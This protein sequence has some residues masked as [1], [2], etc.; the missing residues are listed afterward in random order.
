[1]LKVL[2]PWACI[3]FA[4]GVLLLPLRW[5]LA[6]GII[7]AAHEVGHILTAWL[8]G[9]RVSGFSAATWGARIH[10]EDLTP[11][12]ELL[13]ALS[14]PI[15]GSL[16]LILTPWYPEVGICA[17]AQGIYNLLPVYPLDGGRVIRC[18]LHLLLGD[19]KAATVTEVVGII[20]TVMLW[21]PALYGAVW[22]KLGLFPV[23]GMLL[24]HIRTKIGNTP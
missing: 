21:I 14:G 1:M 3:V 22:L 8:L 20:S 19:N 9:G 24:L 12:R 17:V 4:F 6:W 10:V 11:G 23:L 2:S 7:T 18:L 5:I 13:T 15:A 16:G